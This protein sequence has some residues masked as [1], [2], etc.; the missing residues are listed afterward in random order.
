MIIKNGTVFQDN[1]TFVKKDL[2]IENGK[3]A[4]APINAEVEEIIDGGYKA[5]TFLLK[6]QRIRK[7]SYPR[8]GFLIYKHYIAL[9]FQRKTS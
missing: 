2:Y 9:I 5:I 8:V 3:I 6:R 1:K 7:K 4:N